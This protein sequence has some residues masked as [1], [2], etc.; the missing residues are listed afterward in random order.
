M[1]YEVRGAGKTVMVLGMGCEV[2]G[3]GKTGTV[4]GARYG[5]WGKQ[6]FKTGFFSVLNKFPKLC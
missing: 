6:L 4:W 1:G 2:R 3:A 5:V